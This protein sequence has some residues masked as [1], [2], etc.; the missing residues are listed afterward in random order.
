MYVLEC[1][2]ETCQTLLASFRNLRKVPVVGLLCCLDVEDA[3]VASQQ[4]FRLPTRQKL[5]AGRTGESESVE[6][7]CQPT[8]DRQL[9]LATCGDGGRAAALDV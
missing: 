8:W 4:S 7:P 9:T 2:K 1:D 6:I 3:S 5:H